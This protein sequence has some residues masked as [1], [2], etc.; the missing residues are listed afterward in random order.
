MERIDIT[1]L[2]DDTYALLNSL[3]DEIELQ[4][5]C[6]EGSLR[7]IQLYRENPGIQP[8]AECLS[9]EQASVIADKSEEAIAELVKRKTACFALIDGLN[10]FLEHV[11]G[12][13][14]LDLQNIDPDTLSEILGSAFSSL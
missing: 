2:I 14:D 3:D 6:K 1:N 13:P 11:K 4:T 5:Q 12:L 7:V 10:A 8:T 9:E